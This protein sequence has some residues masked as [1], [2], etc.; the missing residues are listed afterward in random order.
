MDNRQLLII[1]MTIMDFAKAVGMA[2]VED[3]TS[4]IGVH[5]MCRTAGSLSIGNTR[6]VMAKIDL[7]HSGKPILSQSARLVI[8]GGQTSK[9]MVSL[10]FGE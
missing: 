8:S 7:N 5:R 6:Q 9:N 1:R 10:N 4:L 3:R 2:Q